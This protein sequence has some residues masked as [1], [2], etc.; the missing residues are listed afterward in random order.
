MLLILAN[1]FIAILTDAYSDV[2]SDMTDD[3]KIS[4][5]FFGSLKQRVTKV[6]RKKI[7]REMQMQDF[8]GD[9]DGMVDASEL[10]KQTGV[11]VARA[12]EIIA[13]H[14]KNGDGV[15]DRKEFE[16]M[17]DKIIE[18][19]VEEEMRAK[20]PM[21]VLEAKVDKLTALLVAVLSKKQS[22]L[23]KNGKKGKSHLQPVHEQQTTMS[24]AIDIDFDVM[25]LATE[26]IISDEEED[27]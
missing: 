27:E 18:R 9:G 20:D 13:E 14:D 3:D 10:A 23:P 6:I 17:K 1:V 2:Q 12:K 25:A 5:N 21:A 16:R 11:T 15:L 19:H 4:F 7:G 22:A 26:M 8:D 24:S